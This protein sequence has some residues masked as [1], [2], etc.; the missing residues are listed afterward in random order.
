MSVIHMQAGS[1]PYRI[2]SLD[3]EAKAEF[4]QIAAG[5]RST[6]REMR[7]LRDESAEAELAPV[8]GLGR[9]TE[10]VESGGTRRGSRRRCVTH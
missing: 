4:R 10:L 8:A 3:P 7:Q 5:A 2:K 6:L 1:A 9:L